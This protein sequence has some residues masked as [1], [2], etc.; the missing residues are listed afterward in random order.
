MS[1]DDRVFVTSEGRH[2]AVLEVRLPPAVRAR[3]TST[4]EPPDATTSA[5]APQPR[6]ELPEQAAQPGRD[7]WQ[8]A[9]GAGLFL[10]AVLV[11]LLAVRPNVRRPRR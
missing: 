10:A 4:S 8:W 1:E 7:P 11:L 6:N 2:Q 3:M 5:P 9:L